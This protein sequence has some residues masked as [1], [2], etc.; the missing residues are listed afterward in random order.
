MLE[1]AVHAYAYGSVL[2][3]GT[4]TGIQGIAAAMKGCDVTFSDLDK[5]ALECAKGNA[6]ANGVHG[7][8]V[9]SDMFDD[10]DGSFDTIIFNPPYLVGTSNDIALDGGENGR[11]CIDGFIES[12]RDHVNDKHKVLLLESS[13]N[14]YEKDVKRL[15]ATV[16]AKEHYFFEDIVVL[17]F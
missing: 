1:S 12:Y 11:R 5:R 9:L 4:G 16:V 2:D 7:R 15:G 13:F 8:F 3:M 10:I 6:A 17:L 14:M